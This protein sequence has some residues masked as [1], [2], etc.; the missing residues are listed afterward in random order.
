MYDAGLHPDEEAVVHII[1]DAR[2]E[3]VTGSNLKPGRPYFFQVFAVNEFG[4]GEPSEVAEFNT[5]S[6]APAPPFPPVM[7][8]YTHCSL[9]LAMHPDEDSGSLIT[10][11]TLKVSDL[12][13]QTS[14][15]IE[16]FEA[17]AHMLDCE[18]RLHFTV[19]KLKPG[20]SYRVQCA[21]VNG[22]GQSAWS[23]LSEEYTTKPTPPGIIA[24]ASVKISDVQMNTFRLEWTAPIDNGSPITEY[25]VSRCQTGKFEITSSL[26]KEERCPT[27]ELLV[28]DCPPGSTQFVRVSAHNALGQGEPSKPVE[29][30]MKIGPPFPVGKPVIRDITSHSVRLVWAVPYDGGDQVKRFWVRWMETDTDGASEAEKDSGEMIVNGLKRQINIQRLQALREYTF[31][32]AAENSVGTG[33]YGEPTDSIRTKPPEIPGPPGQPFF[34]SA[35]MTMLTC[36]WTNAEP[37]GSPILGQVVRVSNDASMPEDK[38][39]DINLSAFGM[40]PY[41]PKAKRSPNK[42]R[43]L[44]AVAYD[45]F[46]AKHPAKEVRSPGGRDAEGN[47]ISV[48]AS[49]YASL[50]KVDLASTTATG[51]SEDGLEWT[52]RMDPSQIPVGMAATWAPA[53]K[54]QLA[55]TSPALGK[56]EEAPNISR[57]QTDNSFMVAL[58]NGRSRNTEDY[59]FEI[60][61]LRGGQDYY[62]AVAAF[63]KVGRGEFSPVSEMMSTLKGPPLSIEKLSFLEQCATS[64]TLQW[65]MPDF[66]GCP[67]TRYQI[68]C[69]AV[70]VQEP[71]VVVDTIVHEYELRPQDVK[72]QE[73]P[74]CCMDT[75]LPGNW[76]SAMVCSTNSYG[77]SPWVTVEA[78]ERTLAMVPEK[79]EPP[80]PITEERTQAS[81]TFRWKLPAQRGSPLIAIELRHMAA[82][83]EEC[84]TDALNVAELGEQIIFEPDPA[85]GEFPTKHVISGFLPGTM[86]AIVSR[87]INAVGPGDWSDR[88]GLVG[89]E[90]RRDLKR[91]ESAHAIV[92]GDDRV[93]EKDLMPERPMSAPYGAAKLEDGLDEQ[94][95]R[96]K[97]LDIFLKYTTQPTMPSAPE[98]PFWND[99]MTTPYSSVFSFRVGKMNGMVY[100]E[101][102]FR[103]FAG[104]PGED[105]H[106]GPDGL[107]LI[108]D[109]GP[110]RAR[111]AGG[112]EPE[113]ELKPVRDFQ[114]PVSYEENSQILSK[115]YLRKRWILDLQPGTVYAVQA[116]TA[117]EL[118]NSEWSHVGPPMRTPP[119]RPVMTR[120]IL[121]EFTS[122]SHVQLRWG[123]PYHNGKA[124]QGYDIRYNAKAEFLPLSQW[125]RIPQD[126]LEKKSKQHEVDE[127]A[128]TYEVHGLE[129]G[130]PHYFV[131]RARNEV[132]YSDWSEV[133]RFVTKPSR[134]AKIDLP[135][136]EEARPTE[137]LIKWQEPEYHGAPIQRYECLASMKKTIVAW[138]R[139]VGEKLFNTNDLD[140]LFGTAKFLEEELADAS[141]LYEVGHESMSQLDCDEAFYAFMAP[142]KGTCI[143]EMSALLPGMN[144]YFM[145]R[146]IS[147]AGKGNWSNITGPMRTDNLYPAKPV[148]MKVESA[149]ISN[150]VFSFTL[151]Y[152]NG[153]PIESARLVV[154]RRDGP[155]A[156]HEV[157]PETGEVHD[158]VARGE[159]EFDPLTLN[160]VEV[161][162]LLAGSEH[163]VV[164]ACVNS[165]GVGFWSD[166]T[167]FNTLAGLPDEPGEMILPDL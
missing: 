117:N 56:A 1:R 58:A 83:I 26:H 32:I 69:A 119:D 12:S 115:E 88:P 159:K 37:N 146:G 128:L 104:R 39:L 41:R 42:N 10:H 85:T 163:E 6:A 79:M 126:L 18:D 44:K 147:D 152:C 141:G 81:V 166:P 167:V 15:I 112:T 23:K 5:Y 116:Y 43:T 139:M 98:A 130:I 145:V 137:L 151:P 160:T 8:E 134:P 38:S 17:P 57:A 70:D 158:H 66:Q 7:V 154:R 111:T 80:E 72:D 53:A 16:P 136:C 36:H 19:N 123:P 162:G 110:G 122:P 61:G 71:G 92:E 93:K 129:G 149:S 30:T 96:V 103:L 20:T 67:I 155:V 124:I 140:R 133:S 76:Y 60:P 25:T 2:P 142:T 35:T 164:W 108:A 62:M 138:C 34:I 114:T 31:Q 28:K 101:F 77:T 165:C 45:N 106:Y 113:F 51:N 14:W 52:Y 73:K 156:D 125:T 24:K 148:P 63:N 3:G 95:C 74:S 120:A 22:I 131:F 47:F 143:Y 4:E 46:E 89:R 157:H 153:V 50:G 21:A 64:L 78:P 105:F 99:S 132:G 97:A 144:Y 54:P 118:G 9:V 59:E 40:R 11:Y 102:G 121:S 86:V 94:G 65:D 90:K 84:T 55:Q 135:V 82:T 48:T 161:N 27:T 109:N 29:V 13:T 100:S 68:L 87:G 75:L 127:T 150:A 33:R 107:V 49:P 91:G